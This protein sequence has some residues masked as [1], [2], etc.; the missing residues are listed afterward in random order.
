M[1]RAI[2]IV[3]FVIFAI[4]VT[5]A[6][7]ARVVREDRAAEGTL[8]DEGLARREEA[9]DAVNFGRFERFFQTERRKNSGDSLGQHR[10]AGAG[11]ADENDIVPAGGRDLQRALHG[12]LAFDVGE[13]EFVGIF[14]SEQ[15]VEVDFG[16]LDRMS[17]F[18]ERNGFPKILNRINRQAS[19]HAGFGRVLDRDEQP[20]FAGGAGLHGDLQNAFD[21]ANGAVQGEF[22][23][24]H[25]FV[26]IVANHLICRGDDADRDRQIET[27]AFLANVG[28]REINCAA[29]QRRFEP[30]ICQSGAHPVARFLHGRVGQANND[31][32]CGQYS[33]G[34]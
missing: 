27:R 14:P 6:F 30:G 12:F 5:A 1:K 28:G 20:G 22:A 34:P 31:Y 33:Q 13:I 3:S 17:A 24:K 15:R 8:R 25:I 19:D 16:W 2:P 29:A 4:V 18:D 23:D 10:F 11:R 26:E 32:G 21:G 9:D 7:M